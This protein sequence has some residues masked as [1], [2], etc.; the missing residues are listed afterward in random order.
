METILV[1]LCV[2]PLGTGGAWRL[3]PVSVTVCPDKRVCRRLVS[4]GDAKPP[5]ST[6]GTA[7]RHLHALTELRPQRRP[8]CIPTI[9]ANQPLLAF[10]AACP[11]DDTTLEG[12]ANLP[13]YTIT[14]RLGLGVGADPDCRSAIYHGR[15]SLKHG[16]HV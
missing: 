9:P 13:V 10:S 6:D 8:D 1:L 14:G 4:T 12:G 5:L 11:R 16:V 15:S 2:M 3:A 7:M